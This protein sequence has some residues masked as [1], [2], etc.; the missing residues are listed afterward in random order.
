MEL[1]LS[2]RLQE[3]R[4]FPAIDIERSSTRREELLISPDILKQVWLMR[5]MYLQ[6][7]SNPPQG[8]GM[9]IAVASDAIINKMNK[10]KNN[11][12]FLEALTAEK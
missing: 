10:T 8:A 9:D 6:M 2:R 4:I 1:H 7:I 12:E 11:I 5:R 3:R